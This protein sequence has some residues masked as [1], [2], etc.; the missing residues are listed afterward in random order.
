MTTTLYPYVTSGCT[1]D[2]NDFD[3]DDNGSRC[4]LPP[5]LCQPRRRHPH[6]HLQRFGQRR[7]GE[8][9]PSPVL[10]PTSINDRFGHL[11]RDRQL[12]HPQ[13]FHRQFRRFLGRQLAGRQRGAHAQ[14]QANSFRVYLPTDGG[15]APAK[16]YLTQKISLCFR[17][18]PAASSGSAHTTTYMRVIIDFHQ[19]HCPRRHLF[20]FQPGHGLRARGQG[21]VSGSGIC[22]RSRK[23]RSP[24]NPAAGGSGNVTWNPGTVAAGT[25]VTLYYEIRRDP[26]GDN[27]TDR[28]DRDS[29]GQRHYRPLCR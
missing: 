1:V 6:H 16:P 5:F 23:G 21:A 26:D 19:P 3:G 11:D 12:H 13:R 22:R 28:L 14:P 7:L 25:T 24:P 4:L 18:Q 17:S 9:G 15:G 10:A 20:Q 8:P 27:R 2:W 29:R